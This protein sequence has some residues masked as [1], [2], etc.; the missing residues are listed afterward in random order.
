MA[1]PK[2]KNLKDANI[3]TADKGQ[4]P[5]DDDMGSASAASR[6]ATPKIISPAAKK[7]QEYSDS[8][9]TRF[10]AQVRNSGLTQKQYTNKVNK[11]IDEDIKNGRYAKGGKVSSA[12]SRADGCC[13]KGKTKGRMV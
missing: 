6:Q 5:M 1:D 9:S 10:D 11:Q 8:V 13:V 4:P 3:Y 12:S 2:P 7:Q